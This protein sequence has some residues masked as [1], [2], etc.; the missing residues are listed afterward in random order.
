LIPRILA[1][2][3]QIWKL[4]NDKYPDDSGVSVSH[5]KKSAVRLAGA[6]VVMDES[7]IESI[8]QKLFLMKSNG[9]SA[10][11]E[12]RIDMTFKKMC[13]NCSEVIPLIA[14]WY[15][16][17]AS[18]TEFLATIVVPGFPEHVA[19]FLSGFA[20]SAIDD[21]ETAGLDLTRKLIQCRYHV[22][23]VAV[24][25]RFE[26]TD[27]CFGFVDIFVDFIVT[28]L[29]REVSIEQWEY[30]IRRCLEM[31]PLCK[32][33][34]V[35]P[36]PIR[37]LRLLVAAGFDLENLGEMLRV[38]AEMVR[39]KNENTVFGE[40]TCVEICY[41]AVNA[42]SRG[43]SGISEELVRVALPCLSP[44]RQA[45]FLTGHISSE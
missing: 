12:K 17:D 4:G 41:L 19:S 44:G 33:F 21:G 28:G 22:D 40:E 43:L 39:A 34:D 2:V 1:Q 11:L 24:I 14:L 7:H 26:C 27:N 5:V 23:P 3:F 25:E 20:F 38:L 8:V 45:E 35:K 36:S 18:F 29:Y 31:I 37:F 13:M 10:S 9:P 32:D 6:L 16:G 30:V 42:G 15:E